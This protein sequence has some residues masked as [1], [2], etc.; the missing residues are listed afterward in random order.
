[1]TLIDTVVSGNSATGDGGGGIGIDSGTITLVDSIVRNNTAA[2]DG[3]GIYVGLLALNL[4]VYGTS[5]V[6]GN[7]AGLDGGGILHPDAQP[8]DV[9]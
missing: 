3:G 7:H 9:L 6:R 5:S 2:A 4:S 8:G 1:M